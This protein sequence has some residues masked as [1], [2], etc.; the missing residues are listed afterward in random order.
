MKSIYQPEQAVLCNMLREYREHAK[1]NQEDAAKLMDIDRTTLTRIEGGSRRVDFV[2]AVRFC[3]V[4]N[5]A[6][7]EFVSEFERRLG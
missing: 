6:L 1:L 7:N 3:R 4:Y 5:V 2:E